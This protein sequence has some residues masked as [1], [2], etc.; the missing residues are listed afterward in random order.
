MRTLIIAASAAL[1]LWGCAT[2]EGVQRQAL[3]NCQAVGITEKD[4]QF[5]TCVRSFKLQSIQ[6][7]LE[8][9]YHEALIPVR[10]DRRSR[11]ELAVLY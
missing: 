5:A 3:N 7:R 4:P 6:K 1:V 2:P 8:R 11:H 10:E 9:D